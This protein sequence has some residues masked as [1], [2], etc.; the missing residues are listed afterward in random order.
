MRVSRKD[1]D[2]NAVSVVS[3]VSGVSGDAQQDSAARRPALDLLGPQN[4]DR[5]DR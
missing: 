1:T 5:G 3:V 4:R 2:D